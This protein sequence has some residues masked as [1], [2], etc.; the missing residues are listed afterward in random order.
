MEDQG[1]ILS[2]DVL[3]GLLE[4]YG[5]G[6]TCICFMGGDSSPME[7]D[8]L[9][10]FIKIHTRGKIKTGWYS[11]KTTIAAGCSVTNFDYI[12]LG[13][14]IEHL[15]GLDSPATNQRFYRID[16]GKMIDKTFRFQKDRKFSLSANE[17]AV[18]GF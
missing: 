7:V 1:D 13:P 6:I 11:G 10:S 5:N 8:G 14:Y 3:I 15:G 17:K 18:T 16:D 2:E 4:K 9:A 12:K